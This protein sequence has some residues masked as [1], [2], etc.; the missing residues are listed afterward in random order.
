MAAKKRKRTSRSSRSS[1]RCARPK[2]GNARQRIVGVL[3][4]RHWRHKGDG[5]TASLYGSIPWSGARGN[6]EADWEIVTSGWTWEN[7]N[8]TIGLGRVP[9]DTKEEA[10]EIMRKV[11]ER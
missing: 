11:N 2:H 8:G 7:A 4:A 6:T 5:R 10:E 1:R 9:A 3:P